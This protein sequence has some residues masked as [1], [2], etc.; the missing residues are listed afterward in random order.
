[1]DKS[2]EWIAIESMDLKEGAFQVYNLLGITENPNF[3]ANKLL[4]HNRNAGTP[5]TAG[6]GGGTGGSAG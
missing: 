1:M 4:V 3:Y 2:G 6:G 5:G